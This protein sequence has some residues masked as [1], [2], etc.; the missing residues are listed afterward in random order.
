MFADL[1]ALTS[2]SFM[3]LFSFIS[4]F[5]LAWKLFLTGLNWV[6]LIIDT[7]SDSNTLSSSIAGG[8]LFVLKPYVYVLF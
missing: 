6:F 4:F 8:H 7:K 1:S 2:N 3:L 5:N